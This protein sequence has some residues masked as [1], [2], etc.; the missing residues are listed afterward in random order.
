MLTYLLSLDPST[1]PHMVDSDSVGE[2]LKHYDFN[3]TKKFKHWSEFHVAGLRQFARDHH[4]TLV[5]CE[6]PQNFV[7]LSHKNYWLADLSYSDWANYWLI[8]NKK[9]FGNFPVLFEH[10]FDRENNIRKQYAFDTMSIDCFL[11][12]EQWEN[13]YTRIS[14][15][16]NIPQ[17]LDAARQL[18]QSWYQLRVEPFRR[19]FAQLTGEQKEFFAVQRR[20][21]EQQE[22]F[23]HFWRMVQAN[24]SRDR[25]WTNRYRE[26]K[27]QDWPS[28]ECEKDFDLL[29]SAIQTQLIEV[30]NYIPKE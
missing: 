4:Q 3:N 30:F 14:D 26:I 5:T 7:Y 20:R 12:P 25:A 1:V 27:Q 17:Q 9:K 11:D 16:M 13:E 19:Q 28:C 24:G 22:P 18:Y 2:R 6:H 15:S 23:L 8:A 10:E 21:D 29:P